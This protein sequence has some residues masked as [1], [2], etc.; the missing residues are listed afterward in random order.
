MLEAWAAGQGRG[1]GCGRGG[2]LG[3][4][5]PAE[6]FEGEP[7]GVWVEERP[8]QSWVPVSAI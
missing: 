2:P 8:G 1:L 6:L 3:S 7:Q 5:R 4:V